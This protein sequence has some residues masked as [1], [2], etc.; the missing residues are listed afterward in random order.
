MLLRSSGVTLNLRALAPGLLL[1][2]AGAIVVGWLLLRRFISLVLKPAGRAAA[3]AQ[4]VSQ[5]DLRSISEQEAR[6]D[7]KDM[8]GGISTVPLKRR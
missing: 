5:G 3:I 1:V 6:S 4:R 2:A 8:G 7:S